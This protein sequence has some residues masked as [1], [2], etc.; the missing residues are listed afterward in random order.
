MIE[1]PDKEHIRAL[2]ETD[3][4]RVIEI[5]AKHTG[6]S[7]RGFF[8]KRL[9]AALREPH[10]FVYVGYEDKGELQGFV[11]ARILEGEF[12]RSRVIA[13]MDTIAVD[14][15]TPMKGVGQSLMKGLEDVLREKDIHEIQTQL[16]W[17]NFG[18]LRFL[19]YWGFG[20][21]PRRVVER[22]TAE[23]ID[24]TE[25][26]IEDFSKPARDLVACRSMTEDD[27]RAMI[28]IARKITGL[29]QTAYLEHKL[30]EALHVS[31]IRVSLVAEL[32][33]NVTAYIMA[34]VD[35]GDFGKTEPA[36]VIDSL[37]VDPD[38]AHHELGSALLSQ[39]LANLTGLRIELVRTEARWNQF[40]LLSF[41]DHNGFEPSQ[42][43][44]L[45]RQLA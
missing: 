33:G 30:D 35:F 14:P 34:G 10:R 4:D 22:S 16:D 7:R 31:G 12:G 8:E 15:D 23:E 43:L 17:T 26:P 40:D 18:L 6:R 5:D 27:L 38:F 3:L 37:G 20:L 41:L 21:A 25:D 36:A 2:T 9:A 42:R 44:A 32:D 19:S 24:M 39:L 28:R 45:T 1:K 13:A 29:D 11:M